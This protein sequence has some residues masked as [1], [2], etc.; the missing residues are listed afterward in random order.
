MDTPQ[1]EELGQAIVAIR[2]RQISTLPVVHPILDTLQVHSS[3]NALVA[4]QANV[5]LGR[6]VLLPILNPLLS[7][8]PLYQVYE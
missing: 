7:T 8:R 3:T 4:S 2:P 1:A 5:E 6:V